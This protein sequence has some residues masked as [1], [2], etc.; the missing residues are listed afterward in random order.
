M[1]ER[2]G[3]PLTVLLL[4]V[5]HFKRVNDTCGHQEG[6]RVL[7]AIAVALIVRVRDQ[8]IVARFG[9]EEF[10]VLLPNTDLA[11]ATAVAEQLRLG[12]HGVVD[13]EPDLSVSVGVAS[14]HA[15]DTEAT[16]IGHARKRPDVRATPSSTTFSPYRSGSGASDLD[17]PSPPG[18]AHPDHPR[19]ERSP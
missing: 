17:R 8:D 12:C 3:T 15:G 4:D 10:A 18:R 5:D 19:S 2:Q 14:S 16:L 13:V 7:Q 1:A 6:D 11:A 9:G